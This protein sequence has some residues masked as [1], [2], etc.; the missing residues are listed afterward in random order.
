MKSL[1]GVIITLY[2]QARV[3][4]HPAIPIGP[5]EKGK[6]GKYEDYYPRSV[7]GL[8]GLSLSG[9]GSSHVFRKDLSQT[10]LPLIVD[11]NT[12]TADVTGKVGVPEEAFPTI[13]TVPERP[14]TPERPVVTAGAAVR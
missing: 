9:A 6:E 11:P 12:L 4:L 8:G 1:H 13:A 3:D 2:R 5:T 10:V 7:T 14:D